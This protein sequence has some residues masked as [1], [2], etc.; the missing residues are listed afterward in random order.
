MV[1]LLTPP[2]TICCG[3]RSILAAHDHFVGGRIDLYRLL[4]QAVEEL[5]A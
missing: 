3:P 2:T 5:A 4:E 1:I